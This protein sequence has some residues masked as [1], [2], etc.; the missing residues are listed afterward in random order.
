MSKNESTSNYPA[1]ILFDHDGT[2]VDT[3]P[4]WEA[5]KQRIA[6][7]HNAT[8]TSEDT[9][10]VLGY[11]IRKTL[12]QLQK[13]GV[14]L[15]LSELEKKLISYMME[16]FSRSS[17]DFLPGIRPLLD[18]I[19]QAGIPMGIVTNATT[20]VAQRTSELAP[21]YFTALIGDQQTTHPKPN[22][23]PYLLGAKKLGVDPTQCVAVE[24]SPSGV[25][26]ALAAGMKVIVVP[27][28]VPV[29][30]DLG[31]ARMQH[32]ELTLAKILNMNNS[33]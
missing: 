6:A 14:N 2:L 30:E 15:P 13:V 32:E 22:P 5:A 25:Q 20:A 29:P 8:W 31:H 11:S 10:A 33:K 23:E 19:H 1:A 26:S 3:E 7:E 21:G 24:D 17:Y 27:G 16:E 28:E 9:L 18:E 4:L 12:E